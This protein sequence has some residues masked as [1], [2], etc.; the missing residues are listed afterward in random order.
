[1]T[2]NAVA[3]PPV[4]AVHDVGVDLAHGGLASSLV[5]GRSFDSQMPGPWPDDGDCH[6]G[7][8]A[9]LVIAL[10]APKARIMPIR[11]TGSSAARLTASLRFAAASA[12]LVLCAWSLPVDEFTRTLRP[13]FA[14][15]G[16]LVVA[17][18]GS[19]LEVPACLPNVLAVCDRPHSEPRVTVVDLTGLPE[20]EVYHV[21]RGRRTR[22]SRT[23]DG[24]S[25]AAAVVAGLAAR[26]LIRLSASAVLERLSGRSLCYADVARLADSN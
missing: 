7:T 21:R 23:F 19:G 8:L 12:E 14:A 25:A 13:I 20:F 17:S 1:M 15:S 4:V 3:Q 10:V 11:C 22:Q 5:A 26:L 16:A 2:G 18:T 6:H 24:S 9:S